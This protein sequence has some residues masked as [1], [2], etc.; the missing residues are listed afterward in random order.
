MRLAFCLF[1]FFPY[2]GLARDFIRIAE[3]CRRKG[4]SVTVYAMEWR[5]E[6]PEGFTVNVMPARHWSN[7]RRNKL[8]IDAL[9]P[10]LEGEK[11]DLVIGFNKMPGLDV[12][13][14][15]DP[16]YMAK[17]M[18]RRRGLY[19]WGGRFKYYSYCEQ[20]VFGKGS[21]TVSLLISQNQAE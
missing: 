13:Y 2:G 1:K 7:H 10:R 19:R 5:G 4:H 15:A 17:A 3:L 14:A 20:A 6:V 9:L 12:Y 18:G 8:F 16:C 21:E 11:F